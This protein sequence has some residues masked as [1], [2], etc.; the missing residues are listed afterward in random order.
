MELNVKSHGGAKYF[1]TFINDNTHYVWVYMLKHKS[2]VFDKFLE[3]KELVENSSGHK[4]KACGEYMS[5]KMKNFLKKEEVYHELTVPKTPK[6]NGIAEHLNG[7]LVEAVHSMLCDLKL[8]ECFLAK[9]V[10]MAVYL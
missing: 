4:L 8:P 6:Q 7:T 10:S 1:P 2:E 5:N 3:L 9:P